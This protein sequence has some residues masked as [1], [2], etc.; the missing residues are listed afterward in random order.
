MSVYIHTTRSYYVQRTL[1]GNKKEEKKNEMKWWKEREW[2]AA[3]IHHMMKYVRWCL[4]K[5]SFSFLKKK[6]SQN[7]SRKWRKK[8]RILMAVRFIQKGAHGMKPQHSY[9]SLW[10]RVIFFFLFY[11]CRVAG[12][13][14][15]PGEKKT[16]TKTTATERGRHA[17]IFPKIAWY[18][19]CFFLFLF[20]EEKKRDG[21]RRGQPEQHL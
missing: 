20:L 21:K 14:Q 11:F 6:N 16:P 1:K 13:T 5:Y 9:I 12:H 19:V 18:R 4:Y 17:V 3:T 2:P 10:L 7:K 15:A 8:K